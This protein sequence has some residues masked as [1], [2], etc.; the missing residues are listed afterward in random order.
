MTGRIDRR[1]FLCI[2]ALGL[3]G[4]APARALTLEP[5]PEGARRSYLAACEA[6]NLHEQLLAELDAKLGGGG[7]TREQVAAIKIAN[8]CPLCGCPLVG[9][10]GAGPGAPE[11]KN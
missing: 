3:A 6:P 4:A 10:A 2:A 9:D 11:T 1:R 5:M 8:R 7:F